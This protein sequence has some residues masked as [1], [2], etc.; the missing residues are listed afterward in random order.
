LLEEELPDMIH[1]D[2][3]NPSI[4]Y[5][6]RLNAANQEILRHEA[7]IHHFKMNFEEQAKTLK[8][9]IRHAKHPG[10]AIRSVDD[11]FEKVFDE[12]F[13]KDGRAG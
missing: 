9:R 3:K 5:I 11:F 6:K 1:A 2:S 8:E 13:F 4:G 10:V 12:P 7:R